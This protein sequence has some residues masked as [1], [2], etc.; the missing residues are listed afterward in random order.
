MTST[1]GRAEWTARWLAAGPRLAAIRIAE[2]GR[3]DVAA[4]IDSMS[5]A[6]EAARASA[7][8][9]TTSGLAT[10]QRLFAKRRA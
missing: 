2:L 4:F 8:Q 7:S 3:V 6:F 1:D 9:S 10:Q 5:D